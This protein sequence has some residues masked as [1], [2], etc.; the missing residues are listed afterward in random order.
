MDRDGFAAKVRHHLV[1]TAEHHRIAGRQPDDSLARLGELDHHVAHVRL[2]VARPSVLPADPHALRLA[3]GEFQNLRRNPIVEEDNIGGLQGP[4][5]L[6]RQKLRVAGTRPDKRDI[7]EG[8]GFRE[9]FSISK[10]HPA[11]ALL[12]RI[13]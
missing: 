3:P 9:P 2:P 6:E 4:H 8:G 13:R 7:T 11:Y 12:R 5:S 10:K 1:R